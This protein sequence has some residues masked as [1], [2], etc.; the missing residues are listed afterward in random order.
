MNTDFQR[1]EK[2]ILYIRDNF[3][4]QPDLDQVARQVHV[5]PYHFQRMFRDWAGISPKKF[6]QYT[7]LE[8]AKKLLKEHKTLEDASF[9]T[10][11]SGTS[12]LYD[13]FLSI[14]AMTPGEY[15]KEATGIAVNYS[16]ADSPFGEMI[17]A[18]TPIGIC[19]LA[20]SSQRR[21]SLD[22]MHSLFP[23]AKFKEATDSFQQQAIAL[24]QP[25]KE[26]LPRLKLHL[27]GTPFQVKV[28]EAL[29]K[30][31]FGGLSTYAD[32]ALSLGLPKAS[33]AVGAAVGANPVAYLIP[34][35]R[36]ILSSGVIGEYHW[37]PGKKRAII[38]WEA[39]I[40]M[41]SDQRSSA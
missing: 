31:P 41:E 25:G 2:A 17:I 26:T 11:L 32:I 15:K 20:F 16:F 12:R 23:R 6:L 21:E 35:H 30:I 27:R 40:R 13:L 29:L 34:C 10:G 18:S 33:R 3:Q 1:I 19:H 22:N 36:V 7:S 39:A 5:S 24:F 8:Y 37:G 14:E 4:E 28:W 38:G 9:E